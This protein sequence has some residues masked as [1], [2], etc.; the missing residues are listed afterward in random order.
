MENYSYFD[1]SPLQ[2]I[3]WTILGGLLT[4]YAAIRDFKRIS[5]EK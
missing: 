2:L 1:S 4:A 5:L 3:G